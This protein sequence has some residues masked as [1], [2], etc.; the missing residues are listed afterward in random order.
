MLSPGINYVP[1][2]LLISS[3]VNPG[4]F[5]FYG[6]FSTNVNGSVSGIQIIN[7]GS[8]Y[9]PNTL[10]TVLISVVYTG[11]QQPQDGTVSN[12]ILEATGTNYLPGDIQVIGSQG[13]GFIASFGVSNNGSL[14][15]SVSACH[16]FSNFSLYLLFCL[17]LSATVS[18]SLFASICY[19]MDSVS[20]LLQTD[21]F[22]FSCIMSF[23]FPSIIFFFSPFRLLLYFN[24]LLA[25]IINLPCLIHVTVLVTQRFSINISNHGI[26]FTTAEPLNVSIVYKGTSTEQVDPL[27]KIDFGHVPSIQVAFP[28]L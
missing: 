21:F 4:G 10:S 18:Y 20:F 17:F 2:D 15:R 22:S 8:G 1:G 14:T 3:N 19:H 24:L 6:K 11:T 5:D 9:S 27:F 7:A 28:G 12:L 26:G 16:L 23:L 25:M 13:S